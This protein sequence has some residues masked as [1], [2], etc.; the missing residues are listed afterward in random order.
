[1]QFLCKAILWFK[2]PLTQTFPLMAILEARYV[3]TDLSSTER[4]FTL[5]KSPWAE[6]QQIQTKSE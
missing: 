4:G 2:S 1:M 5:A 3:F 6:L